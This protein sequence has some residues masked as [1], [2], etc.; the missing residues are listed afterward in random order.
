[1]IS[2]GLRLASLAALLATIPLSNAETLLIHAGELLA[3]DF[4]MKGGTIY[5]D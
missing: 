5:K 2:K 1:M 4:V 3:V